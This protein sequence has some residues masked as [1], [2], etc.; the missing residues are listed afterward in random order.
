METGHILTALAAF[1]GMAA[2]DILRTWLFSKWMVNRISRNSAGRRAACPR[3][4]ETV[5]IRVSISD[6]P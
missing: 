6:R 2:W 1:G 5:D 4:G 3:C